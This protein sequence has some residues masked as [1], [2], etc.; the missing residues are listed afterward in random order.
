[1]GWQVQDF[2]VQ[3]VTLITRYSM[4][5]DRRNISRSLAAPFRVLL[6]PTVIQSS[7]RLLR[8]CWIAYRY[9]RQ[10]PHSESVV[11]AGR[12]DRGLRKKVSVAT[13][14]LFTKHVGFGDRKTAPALLI[15][16]SDTADSEEFCRCFITVAISGLLS[17]QIRKHISASLH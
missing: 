17:V 1:M 11:S 2:C 6:C 5:E 16:V 12:R 15:F 14:I 7:G 9:M 3:V 4:A 13:T 8:R 10:P